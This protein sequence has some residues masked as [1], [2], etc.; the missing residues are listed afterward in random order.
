MLW[1][2]IP[3]K[4]LSLAPLKT[5]T[6][7]I[8]GLELPSKFWK[9]PWTNLTRHPKN[10]ITVSTNHQKSL[11]LK[12]VLVSSICQ[13]WLRLFK[14]IYHHYAKYLL[15]WHV[16][17]QGPHV[18]FLVGI[19]TRHNEEDTRSSSSPTE[20]SPQPKDDHPFVFLNDL[21]GETKGKWH[22]DEDQKNGKEGDEMGAK[23][24]AFIASWK[25][26]IE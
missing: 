17:G 4:K 26:I 25:M 19:Y 10:I 6:T 7:F 14:V 23:A 8:L 13:E 1:V 22:G 11:F 21:D 20:E 9:E 5:F 24:G 12:I 15:G 2:R 3:L 18:H 16:K